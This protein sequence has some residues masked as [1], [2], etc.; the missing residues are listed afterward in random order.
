MLR[1]FSDILDKLFFLLQDV[2]ASSDALLHAAIP[3]TDNCANAFSSFRNVEINEQK[4]VC[5][6]KRGWDSCT[7]DSGGPLVLG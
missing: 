3:I 7:G 1:L 4:Q 6:G 2:G 5:A